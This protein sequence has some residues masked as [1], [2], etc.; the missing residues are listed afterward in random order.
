MVLESSE[1]ALR[2]RIMKAATR[3]SEEAFATLVSRHVNLVYSIGLRQLHDVH[4]AEEV[5]Q[6]YSRNNSMSS[7]VMLEVYGHRQKKVTKLLHS[8]FSQG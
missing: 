1:A 6:A 5:T 8:I 3:H 4:L 2:A 7:A